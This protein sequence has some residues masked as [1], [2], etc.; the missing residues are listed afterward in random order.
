MHLYQHSAEWESEK[1]NPEIA[2]IYKTISFD[3][4]NL[5]IK[6]AN[7]SHFLDLKKIKFITVKRIDSMLKYI[8]N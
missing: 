4:L 2:L 1:K 5:C 3:T 8:E 6:G 7:F